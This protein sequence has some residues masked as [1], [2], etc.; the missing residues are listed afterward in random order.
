ML[1][2]L[3]PRA[4]RGCSNTNNALNQAGENRILP[5]FLVGLLFNIHR[6]FAV[7]SCWTMPGPAGV[8]HALH[9]QAGPGPA[10]STERQGA[11]ATRVPSEGAGYG[12][13]EGG[14]AEESAE[15]A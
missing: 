8:H 13:K 12:L 9:T 5:T 2:V 15:I 6:S 4:A 3:L 1:P 7:C 14:T 11:A 10:G